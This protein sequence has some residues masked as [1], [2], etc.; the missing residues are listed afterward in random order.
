VGAERRKRAAQCDE[1]GLERRPHVRDLALGPIKDGPHQAAEV[2]E[3]LRPFAHVHVG[4][5]ARERS[6]NDLERVT[7][8]LLECGDVRGQFHHAR[9]D[10]RHRGEH[11]GNEPGDDRLRQVLERPLASGELTRQGLASSLRGAT[12]LGVELGE[13]DLLG[14]DRVARLLHGGDLVLLALRERHADTGQGGDALGRVVQR[15]A[16]QDRV[17]RRVAAHLRGHVGGGLRRL[18]E[19][20]VR[21]GVLDVREREQQLLGLHDRVV[22]LA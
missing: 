3:R 6:P 22:R 1:H 12:E 5:L 18:V 7:D 11:Y 8:V 20:L 19:D 2:S 10:P 16:E 17:R 21:P 13:D 15:L 14:A 9:R 4:A